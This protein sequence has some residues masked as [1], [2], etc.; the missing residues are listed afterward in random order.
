MGVAVLVGTRKGRHRS[1]L[2]IC[3]TVSA[4]AFIGGLFTW[5]T[6]ALDAHKAPRALTQAAHVQQTDHDIRVGCFEYFQP[7]L[8][9]YCRREVQRLESAEQVL[10]FLRSP[11]PVYLF[12]PA[13]VW[14]R[15]AKTRRNSCRRTPRFPKR[16]TK[17]SWRSN[18]NCWNCS[19]VY[20]VI[21]TK[22][23]GFFFH[24]SYFTPQ[25]SHA[26]MSITS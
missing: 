19:T 26:R 8:V 13:T 1:G 9:F 14:D 22:R 4:I 16:S 21:A 2:L 20:P 23:V 18:S 11:L 12:V 5:G 15:G 17:K 3:V 24:C 6:V 7:S 25:N 10:E